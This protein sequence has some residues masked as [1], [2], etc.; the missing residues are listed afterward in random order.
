M[1]DA[2]LRSLLEQYNKHTGRGN[3]IA[4]NHTILAMI[5][6]LAEKI[7]QPCQC[8]CGKATARP[9]IISIDPG[10]DVENDD[11][12]EITQEPIMEKRKAGRPRRVV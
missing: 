8:N 4:A 3:M 6:V 7:N 5:E 1:I 10:P 2:N 9:S 12:A 11:L